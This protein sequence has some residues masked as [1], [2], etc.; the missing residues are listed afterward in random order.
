MIPNYIILAKS[1]VKNEHKITIYLT[2]F[3]LQFILILDLKMIHRIVTTTNG[4]II[5]YRYAYPSATKNTLK[6]Q[7]TKITSHLECGEK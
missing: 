3:T 4:I 7:V 2:S 5:L 6:Q 1:N